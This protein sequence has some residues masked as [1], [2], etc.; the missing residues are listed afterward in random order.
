MLK[1]TLS[2]SISTA[3]SVGTKSKSEWFL[4]SA[5]AISQAISKSSPKV[6]LI[7]SLFPSPMSTPCTQRTIF[8]TTPTKA[9]V[10]TTPRLIRFWATR[11]ESS[12]L[13]PPRIATYGRGGFVTAVCR[14]LISRCIK[15]PAIQGKSSAKPVKVGELRCAAANASVT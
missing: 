2:S 1:P 4:T 13:A 12:A 9:I 3:I 6:P 7:N 5:L 11:N 14:A 8:P 10:S 15:R